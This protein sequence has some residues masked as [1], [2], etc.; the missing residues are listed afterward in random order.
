MNWSLYQYTTNGICNISN[1][2]NCQ[3]W[4]YIQQKYHIKWGPICEKWYFE[5]VL[6]AKLPQSEVLYFVHFFVV[7]IIIQKPQAISMAC[8]RKLTRAKIN[9]KYLI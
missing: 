8:I 4:A 5:S 7:C 2:D 3:K 1:L 6:I 9:K